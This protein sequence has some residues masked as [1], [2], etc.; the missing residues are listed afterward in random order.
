[1]SVFG[2]C[3]SCCKSNTAVQKVI[4]LVSFLF[5]RLRAAFLLELYIYISFSMPLFLLEFF[6]LSQSE[7]KSFFSLMKDKSNLLQNICRCMDFFAVIGISLALQ[8]FKYK[9]HLT[10]RINNN[11]LTLH[12]I[13]GNNDFPPYQNKMWAIP[14]SS[15]AFVSLVIHICLPLISFLIDPTT[16]STIYYSCFNNLV[17]NGKCQR[18]LYMP[19]FNILPQRKPKIYILK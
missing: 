9:K 1:M 8:N 10:W 15:I 11:F 16:E 5:L 18:Q 3:P 12:Y 14:D 4:I 6:K 2:H 17:R 19:F 13:R 7:H